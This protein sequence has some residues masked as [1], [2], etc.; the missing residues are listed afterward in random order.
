MANASEHRPGE[1]L[2][3]SAQEARSVVSLY[4]TTLRYG[5]FAAEKRDFPLIEFVSRHSDATQAVGYSKS[6][7]LFH[8]LRRDLGDETFTAALRLLWQERQFR[9]TDFAQL[10]ALFERAAGRP[11]PY[12]RQWLEREGAPSLVVEAISTTKDGDSHRLA[13]TLRQRQERRNHGHDAED[14]RRGFTEGAVRSAE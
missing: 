3:T 7:M 9:E 1:A 13:F 4:H 6:L 5:D 2:P 12:S 11:L 14:P 8:M 10:H